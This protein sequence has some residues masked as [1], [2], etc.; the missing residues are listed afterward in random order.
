MLALC[1][2]LYWWSFKLYCSSVKSSPAV[3]TEST[4]SNMLA[5]FHRKLC[6]CSLVS[7]HLLLELVDLHSWYCLIEEQVNFLSSI[8]ASGGLVWKAVYRAMW[9]AEECRKISFGWLPLV[10]G[11]KMKHRYVCLPSFCILQAHDNILVINITE[12]AYSARLALLLEPKKCDAL[13][14]QCAFL[15]YVFL[16]DKYYTRTYKDFLSPEQ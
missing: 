11:H 1:S 5:N 15:H 9:G 3:L 6:I 13:F 2:R 12:H 10:L 7:T 16:A 14:S 4:H 8:Q